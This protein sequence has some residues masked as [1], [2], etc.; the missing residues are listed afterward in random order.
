LSGPRGAGS[1]S[2]AACARTKRPS[3]HSPAHRLLGLLIGLLVPLVLP[4]SAAAIDE[5][6]VPGGGNPGGITTGPDGAIWFTQEGSSEIGRLDPRLAVPGTS[7]GIT[8]YAVTTNPTPATV[9]V[10]D[11]IVAGPDGALWFTEPRDNEIGR[12]ATT[13]VVTNEYTIPSPSQPEGIT[14]GPDGNIW[15]TDLFNEVG[16]IAPSGPPITEFPTGQGPTDITT[17]PDGA[18]W[19]TEAFGNTIGRKTTDGAPLP[20]IAVPTPGSE[21][22]GITNV[23]GSGLWFTESAVN[24]IGHIPLSGGIVEYP[25]AGAGPSAIAAGRDGALWFTE[26]EGNSIGRI[27]TGGTVTNHFPLATPGSQPSDMTIGPDG[28]LWFTEYLGNKIGR[29]DTA[30]PAPVPPTPQSVPISIPTPKKTT[31]RACKVPKVK[32]LSVRKAK[33]KLKKAKCKYRVRGKGYVVST[34]P[35]AGKRTTK[36]VVVKAKPRKKAKRSTR[37]VGSA[38]VRR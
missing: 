21:P 9:P 23:P 10:L 1:G 28:A 8:E 31:K 24:Q 5:Y 11:Q 14:V 25:G 19:F 38:S 2:D 17:G 12:M 3:S 32:R 26:S 33:K 18:L 29:I 6:L 15:F 20:S 22:T 7:N 13:G 4:A 37:R 34:K 36:R 16:R 27:T 30:P 35:K